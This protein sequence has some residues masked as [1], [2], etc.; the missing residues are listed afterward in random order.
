MPP[1]MDLNAMEP[2]SL[3]SG[4]ITVITADTKPLLIFEDCFAGCEEN[5]NI[6]AIQQISSVKINIL[7]LSVLFILEEQR[8][9]IYPT[10]VF[11]YT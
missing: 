3:Y 7:N 4:Q 2:N 8:I 5:I 10:A 9:R 6:I 11:K 1:L